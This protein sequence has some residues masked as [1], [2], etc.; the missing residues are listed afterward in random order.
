MTEY[1]K[2]LTLDDLDGEVWRDVVG[3]GGAYQVSNLGRI[4]STGRVAQNK[5]GHGRGNGR[6]M[7]SK[8][9]KQKEYNKGY[10]TVALSNK[11]IGI[12]KSF[13]VHRLV[14]DAFEGLL[15]GMTVN[16][17][18]LNKKDNRIIAL[19]QIT[20]HDN[21]WHAINNGA[22]NTAGIRNRNS[23]LTN[24]QVVEMRKLFADGVDLNGLCKLFPIKKATIHKIVRRQLWKHVA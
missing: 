2:I 10:L 6:W 13:S 1:Y 15:V 24:E 12:D 16:H 23:K 5:I 4:K 21:V 20:P 18:W 7:P 9:L 17:K 22:R 11:K 8:I 3:L 14:V 19:E